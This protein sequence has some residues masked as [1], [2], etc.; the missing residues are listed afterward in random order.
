MH[1]TVA[2]N[3]NGQLCRR[4]RIDDPL[5]P[6][7]ANPAVARQRMLVQGLR[8]PAA[9]VGWAMDAGGSCVH[10]AFAVLLPPYVEGVECALVAKV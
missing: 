10:H 2:G 6:V 9:L 1:R 7:G 4:E 3:L 5:Q 8:H